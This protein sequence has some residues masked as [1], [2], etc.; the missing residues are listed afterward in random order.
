[1]NPA[2]KS[3]PSGV[4]LRGAGTGGKR[5]RWQWM[6][7]MHWCCSGLVLQRKGAD[8]ERGCADREKKGAYVK[9]AAGKS[10]VMSSLIPPTNSWSAD[11]GATG[12]ACNTRE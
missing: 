12:I 5:R 8:R 9:D 10:R 11:P 6:G 1:M 2:I 7:A 4:A 3:K